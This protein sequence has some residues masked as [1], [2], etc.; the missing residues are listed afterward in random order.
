MRDTA[1]GRLVG[2]DFVAA[3]D[4]FVDAW[5][6]AK[7]QSRAEAKALVERVL[8]EGLT[9]W[10]VASGDERRRS[11]EADLKCQVAVV[12]ASGRFDEAGYLEA[13]PDV[14]ARAVGPLEHFCNNGWQELRNPRSD[15]DLW[16][17]QVEHLDLHARDLNPFLH[18]VLEGASSGLTTLPVAS[19]PGTA[20]ALPTDRPVRRVCL[21]AGYDRDGIVD[22][23]VVAY[24]RELSR[25][26]D[27][28]YLADSPMEQS[29]L[30]K[31]AGITL[32]AWA[33]RHGAYDFGSW[34]ML[35][36]DLVGWD[37]IDG[38]DELLLVNDSCYLL[39]PLDEVFAEMDATACDWWGLQAAKRPNDQDDT[40]SWPMPIEDAVARSDGGSSG[41]CRTRSTSAPTSSDSP[42]GLHPGAVASSDGR[43]R[44]GAAQES[45]H[46]QVRDRAQS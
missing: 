18:Y 6:R 31:L 37:V 36:R 11:R 42:P 5:V 2:A 7:K 24:V 41:G 34:S 27:V 15:F 28:Y 35:A 21:F 22:D 40:S 4:N 44:A 29:E 30:D 20:H 12:R 33:V 43:G 10:I 17:Y 23:Y 46:R 1:A 38:Y 3:W 16:H 13:N 14:A 45:D 8:D 25:F 9:P 26:A 32:G 19:I 39:R